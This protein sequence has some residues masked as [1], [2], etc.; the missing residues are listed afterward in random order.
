MVGSNH[1]N[2]DMMADDDQMLQQMHMNDLA[3]EE[4][5]NDDI[6]EE[7]INNNA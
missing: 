5:N 4:M 2:P 1:G 7:A 3:D 6:E